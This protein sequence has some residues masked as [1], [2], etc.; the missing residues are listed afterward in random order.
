MEKTDRELEKL[1]GKVLENLYMEKKI[2]HS[3]GRLC[4][5]EI[6]PMFIHDSRLARSPETGRTH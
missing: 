1:D 2:S 5:L 6:F 3:C 4:E